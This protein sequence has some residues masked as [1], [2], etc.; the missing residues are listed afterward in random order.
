MVVTARMEFAI[1]RPAANRQPAMLIDTHCHLDAPE[2]AADQ[3]AVLARAAAAGV[4]TIVVPAVARSHFAA[5][6]SLCRES[7]LCRPAY[8]I[9][10]LYEAE[11]DATDFPTLRTYLSKGAVAVGEIGL[12]YF[13][14]PR[15][16]ERQ[17]NL[18]IEQ[19]KIARE[20]DLPVI[21]HVRRAVD[22][23]LKELRKYRVKGGIAHAFNGSYQQAKILI[24]MG[25]AL[26]FGGAMTFERALHIRRLA[27]QLPLDCL[28]LETDAPDIAPAWR[29][30]QRNEPGELPGIASVLAALRHQEVAEVVQ[31]TG[32]NA[33]RVLPGLESAISR[34]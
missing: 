33:L 19:L 7:P 34:I 10:P 8:G 26:G 22:P 21:L 12:D 3:A 23:V 18:F 2:F 24:D 15:N 5:V 32:N 9:H 6:E 4:K 28:V 1:L 27:E 20:F 16:T 11:A 13:V 31:A 17:R 14:E 25:F 29:W 30:K